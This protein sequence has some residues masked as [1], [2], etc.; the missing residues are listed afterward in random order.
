MTTSE[1]CQLVVDLTRQLADVRAERDAHRT[2]VS[3]ALTQLYNLTRELERERAAR[4]RLLNEYRALR[5]QKMPH[6]GTAA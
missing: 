1:A 6:N 2:L 4:Q 3:A 5:E